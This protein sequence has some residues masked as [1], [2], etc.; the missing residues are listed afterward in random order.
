M[1]KYYVIVTYL[2]TV[3]AKMTLMLQLLLNN[4]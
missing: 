4:G 1:P 3:D 2:A